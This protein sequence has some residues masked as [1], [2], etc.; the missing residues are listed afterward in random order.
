M[1][2]IKEYFSGKD[3]T[4]IISQVI[5]FIAAA[6]LLL[7]FQQ[8]THRRIV[9]IQ[10]CSGFLFAVQY[11]MLGA[12]E[13]MIGNVVG[14]T[15]SIAYSFRGRS[16]AVDHIACPAIFAI[17]AGIGGI[18]T[19]SNLASLLPMT[20]MMITSFVNWS[21][22][23]QQ[24]RALNMP[25]SAMWLIYNLIC[26]SYSGT[27]TEILNLISISIGLIRFRKKGNS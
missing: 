15:R 24:L 27:V 21:P 4:F 18:A 1:E 22:K 7:S 5:G 26:S 6:L 25:T 16:K 2:F 10:A 13:G 3:T 17:L 20:A 11:L 9:I 8:R 14:F 19:Y 23:T 12:Y